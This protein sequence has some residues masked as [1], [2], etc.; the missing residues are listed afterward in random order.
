MILRVLLL[1]FFEGNV[2]TKL[3]RILLK[4]KLASNFLLI[5]SGVIYLFRFFVSYNSEVVL[6]F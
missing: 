1:D 3:L 2:L 4:L 5:L 6:D